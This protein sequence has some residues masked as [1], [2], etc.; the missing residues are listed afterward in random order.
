MSK[1]KNVDPTHTRTISPKLGFLGLLGLLGVLG[2]AGF[3]QNAFHREIE[4]F[5]LFFFSLFGCFG[6]FYEG[7]MSNT[8]I[9]ERFELNRNRATSLANCI[10]LFIIV[11][12]S[13]ITVLLFNLEAH[14]TLSIVIATIAFS[15]GL[16][17]FLQQYLLYK[18]EN[19]D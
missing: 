4:Y 16:S 12:V 13:F 18:F 8:L 9:D 10:A 3:F 14:I 15:F 2:F 1:G 19:K 17:F 7:K 6:F 11:G 5:P